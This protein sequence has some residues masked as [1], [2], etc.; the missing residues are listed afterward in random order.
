VPRVPLDALDDTVTV[1]WRRDLA[2]TRYTEK[3]H[4]LTKMSYYA[5]VDRI[6]AT[7]GP[8]PVTW[9]AIV[10]SV[11]PRGNSSTFYG[12]TGPRARHP[13]LR[14][15]ASSECVESLYIALHYQR[16]NPVDQLI[17]EAKVWAYWPYRETW[18][19]ECRRR[20]LVTREVA[21]AAAT[22]G[23]VAWARDRPA[24]AAALEFAPPMCAVE[25]LMLV[26]QGHL[27]A[28]AAV[29]KLTEVVRESRCPP[30]RTWEPRAA[31]R[32]SD[33]LTA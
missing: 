22:A 10:D 11:H 29:A 20:N 8:E 1:R 18:L 32:M 13:L 6:L 23:L 14:A 5:A 33:R 9:R 31:G 30:L 19:V 2:G 27:S 17:D 12:V 25:D 4:W 3:S 15:F 24:L 7:D 26:C 16:V 28:R 21:V